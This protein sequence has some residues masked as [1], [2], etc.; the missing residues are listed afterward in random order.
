MIKTI[1]ATFFIVIEA[2]FVVLKLTKLVAWSWIWVLS[3]IWLLGIMLVGFLL[4]FMVFISVW[5]DGKNK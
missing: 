5:V 4:F 2:V 1:I 3:P